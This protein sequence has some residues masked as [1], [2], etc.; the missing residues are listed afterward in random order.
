MSY[1]A[2]NQEVVRSNPAG[3]ATRSTTYKNS[4]KSIVQRRRVLRSFLQA[5]RN[6]GAGI[7]LQPLLVSFQKSQYE[8]HGWCY[9]HE[10][11]DTHYVGHFDALYQMTFDPT[12][13]DV[14]AL[15]DAIHA[16][17]TV[18]DRPFASELAAIP[19][20]ARDIPSSRQLLV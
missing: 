2:T 7:R 9:E 4:I 6:T 14:Y 15:I 3:R 1:L 19:I 20:R 16:A 13:I 11:S 12:R 10:D 18:I 8:K 5:R 17:R